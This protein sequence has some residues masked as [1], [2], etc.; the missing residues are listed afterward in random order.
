MT[1]SEL[2]WLEE[3][4]TGKSL[5]IEIGSWKGRSSVAMAGAERLI[6]I[7]VFVDR[8]QE[9]GSGVDILPDFS[10]AIGD[11][12]VRVTAIRGDVAEPNFV[13]AI[14]NRYGGEADVV[15]IDAS[16]D[17]ESV[18]RDIATAMRLVKAG[19]IVCG[20]DY[21]SAWPGVVAA[22]NDILPGFQRAGDSIWWSFA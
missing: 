15:F 17:E 4:A 14:A 3:Q 13:D 5:V 1:P 10:A 11:D 21:S 20:H 12:S 6:C 2:S 7:D 19:G 8:Q 9:T 16:H 22:V 18:R